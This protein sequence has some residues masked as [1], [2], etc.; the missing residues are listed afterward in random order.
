MSGTG[1]P[2]VTGWLR[3][4]RSD[5]AH[6]YAAEGAVMVATLLVYRLAAGLGGED[7]D[8]YILVRRTLSFV[9]PLL[10][11][12]LAVGLPRL[13]AMSQEDP[14]RRFYL[15]AALRIVMVLSGIG[16][17]LAVAFPEQVSRL[18]LGSADLEPL[19]MPLALMVLGLCL[20]TVAYSYIRGTHRTLVANILQTT[21]LAV[22]PLLAFA[23]TWELPGIL[24][25]T[26]GAW[27]GVAVLFMLPELLAGP[28]QVA[29]TERGALLRYGLPRLPG[30]LAYAAL[31]TF[32]VL[33]AA[34]NWGLAESGRIGLGVT[35]LNIV[36]AGFAPISILL[37]PQTARSIS[38]GDHQGL[39][40]RIARL[41]R[42]ALMVSLM[43]LVIV[44][45]TLPWLLDI[46]LGDVAAAPYL[47]ACRLIFLAAPALAYFVA[48]RS[49]LDAYH[50]SPRNGVN[51]I[52][53]LLVA[54]ITLLIV[55]LFHLADPWPGLAVVTGL[56]HLAFRTRRE[57]AHV[58]SELRRKVEEG[59]R[60][61]RLMLVIPGRSDGN[62]MPFA[63]RQGRWIAQETGAA[64]DTFFLTERTSMVGLWRARRRF[65]QQAR[66]FR[67]DIVHAHYG[68]ITGLFTVLV[69]PVPVV[70][71]FHG[72]DLNPTPSDGWWR[73]LFGR[74]FS[75]L[76]AFFAAGIICV[77]EGLRQRLWWR[78]DE[79]RVLPMG[80]D[81]SVFKPMDKE[82]CRAEQG[83][84]GPER[85]VLFNGNNPALKRLDIAERVIA[86]LVQRGI[87]ARLQVLTGGVGPD[88]MPQL[89]N[90]CDALLLCSDRE[91]SPTMVKEAMA[92][93]L[94]VVSS[95]V[96]DVR[97]RLRDVR[98]GAVVA[99]EAE[100][101]AQA[102]AP[103]L[104]A[105]SRSNGRELATRNGIDAVVIDRDTHRFLQGLLD[106]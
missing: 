94:P 19:V 53:S 44:E 103:I 70:I 77:S 81:L 28:V 79:V 32:P 37:L 83:W 46:Y 15:L 33:W 86:L 47:P 36:A 89:M 106:R 48:L 98:P 91:G 55:Q 72:S 75:Q 22:T 2:A 26:G 3:M 92:C 20:H 76:A 93:G 31:F 21:G 24:L 57:I 88:R 9:Q 49:V 67:P 102:L 30:D 1:K 87:P 99:Q 42:S 18:L 12:G 73:D 90:A 35:L 4:L 7:L 64:V 50:T 104:S 38:T 10:M 14:R 16:V 82:V 58:R 61:M 41:E 97:E 45:V 11:L 59:A 39:E 8:A 6:T 65:L 52:I 5:H 71:T 80:V 23:F 69:S 25:F 29:R 96:G 68:T 85:H 84:S 17:I 51:I 74:L 63:R 34:H 101:L 105:P 100:A 62:E 43:A 56:G 27:C 78:R 95:D 60:P 13:V 66:M 54:M 40:R